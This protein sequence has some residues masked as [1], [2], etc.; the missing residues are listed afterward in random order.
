MSITQEIR[1]DALNHRPARSAWYGESYTAR[2]SVSEGLNAGPIGTASETDTDSI[3]VLYTHHDN[4]QSRQRWTMR[5]LKRQ[6]SHLPH[7]STCHLADH[8]IAYG[9]RALWQRSSRS[10]L[11]W[12]E[13]TTWRRGT[14]SSDDQHRE[15]REMRTAATVLG[16]IRQRGS[17]KL[18][19]TDVYRQLFNPDLF[20]HA[21]GKIASNDGAMTPG[22]T[23]ETVDGMSLER[24]HKKIGRASCRE[25]V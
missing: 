16:I 19:L 17:H 5:P 2:S 6:T 24:I 21:Y 20:L 13:P 25:R 1:E 18:P 8:G 9:A 12:G 10:S 7:A 23:P 15:V 4:L 11:R 14:G 3:E 22:S